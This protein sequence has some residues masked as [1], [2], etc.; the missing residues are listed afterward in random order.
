MKT[1]DKTYSAVVVV[2]VSAAASSSS[3]FGLLA[4]YAL[5]AHIATQWY[6]GDPAA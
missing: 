2:V 1:H 6:L 5:I 3:F 4:G